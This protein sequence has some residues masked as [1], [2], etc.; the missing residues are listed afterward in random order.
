MRGGTGR[1]IKGFFLFCYMGFLLLL[2]FIFFHFLLF[3]HTIKESARRVSRATSQVMVRLNSVLRIAGK[4]DKAPCT[5][6]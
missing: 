6:R 5:P 1:D 2:L 4:L 3:S